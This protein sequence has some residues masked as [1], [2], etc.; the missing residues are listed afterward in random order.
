MQALAP[1]HAVQ[2]LQLGHVHARRLLQQH[3]LARPQRPLG[4]VQVLR[5]TSLADDR[6]RVAVQRLLDRLEDGD[7]GYVR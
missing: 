3:V 4:V 6:F 1:R 2:P 7:V 5:D